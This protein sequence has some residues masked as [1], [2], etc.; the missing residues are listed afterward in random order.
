M[1]VAIIDRVSK[2]KK[3]FNEKTKRSSQKSLVQLQLV[4]CSIKELLRNFIL[5][6][7]LIS[8][9]WIH[10]KRQTTFV[11]AFLLLF[12]WSILLKSQEFIHSSYSWTVLFAANKFKFT[13]FLTLAH[14]LKSCVLLST[15]PYFIFRYY[16][17][18][19]TLAEITTS[20]VPSSKKPLVLNV[21][22]KTPAN[23]LSRNQLGLN[24]WTTFVN[25]EHKI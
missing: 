21:P 18:V 13:N 20:V 17:L 23:S 5:F 2:I 16:H 9:I 25:P 8:E 15:P 11:G 10:K 22:A 7:F 4:L 19:T 3:S 1:L 6:F 14:F 24:F 12:F